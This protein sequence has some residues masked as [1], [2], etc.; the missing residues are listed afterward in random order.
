MNMKAFETLSLIFPAY[1]E[2]ARIVNTVNEAVT[3]FEKQDRDYEIIVAADGDDG[4]RELVN[5]MSQANSRL[6]AIGS[7]ECRGKRRGIREAVKRATC[8]IIGFA[9]ANKKTPVTELA[10]VLHWF[11]QRYDIVRR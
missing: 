7:K 6:K 3:Y 11:E 1:N 8:E 2:A 10:K 9:D 5:H 4:T